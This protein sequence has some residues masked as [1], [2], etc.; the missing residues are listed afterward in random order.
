MYSPYH[1]QTSGQ[2]EVT[3][4][5]MKLILQKM[6]SKSTMNWAKELNDDLWALEPLVRILWACLLTK[7]FMEKLVTCLKIWNIKIWATK[8][9]NDDF[10]LVGEKRL[11]DMSSL[12]EWRCEAYEN[13]SCL[14]KKLRS[15][16][17]QDFGK[18]NLMLKI[19]YYYIGPVSDF[20]ARKL[21]SK[22]IHWMVRNH[23]CSM[24]KHSSITFLLTHLKKILI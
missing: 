10:K 15:G 21:L 7:W 12:D 4:R 14:K 3:N 18:G 23:K 11:L 1:P 24:V 16:M 13:A 22:L 9:L 20:F 17:I 6:V 5:E 2:V 8:E 19:N